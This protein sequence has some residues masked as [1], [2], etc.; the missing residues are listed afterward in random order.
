VLDL[1][2]AQVIVNDNN[3]EDIRFDPTERTGRAFSGT[4]KT[5]APTTPPNLS[6]V[7]TQIQTHTQTEAETQSECHCIVSWT[8]FVTYAEIFIVVSSRRLYR[9]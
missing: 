4:C 1:K 6:T 8:S 3:C 2:H 5:L 9:V 7:Q